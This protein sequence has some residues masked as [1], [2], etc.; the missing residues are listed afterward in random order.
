MDR[1]LDEMLEEL[2]K[3]SS[4]VLLSEDPEEPFILVDR[5]SEG[6]AFIA[7]SPGEQLRVINVSLSM[8]ASLELLLQDSLGGYVSRDAILTVG[9]GDDE[10]FYAHSWD[11]RRRGGR[12]YYGYEKAHYLLLIARIYWCLENWDY[13]S[14]ILRSF[15]GRRDRRTGL[16]M[17]QI[18]G[19]LLRRRGKELR[20]EKIPLDDLIWAN[21]TD[22]ET[23]ERIPP[24][25]SVEYCYE[26]ECIPSDDLE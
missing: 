14:L 16:P 18:R 22:P 13:T 5:G 17:K 3:G 20:L 19:F 2:V 12:L 11:V 10:Y 24:E 23:G 15:T 8:I 6:L 1:D 9:C 21:T 26:K 25:P 4:R 7:P